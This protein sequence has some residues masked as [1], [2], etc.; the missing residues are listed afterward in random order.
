MADEEQDQKTEYPTQK[1]IQ[2]AM[3][4]GNVP[5][6]REITN[7]LIVIIMAFT[8]GVFAPYMMR[9]TVLL[10]GPFINAPETLAT[11]ATGL[12]HIMEDVLIESM[13]I[14]ALPVIF[15]MA[16]ALISRYAQSGFFISFEV[17]EFKLSKLSP[18]AGIKRIFSARSM[19]EFI[20][21]VFKLLIVGIIGFLAVYPELAHIRQ[22]PDSSIMAI[23][24]FLGK[25][26]LNMLIGVAI[27]MFFIA[28]FDFF[29][30]RYDYHKKLRMTKQEVKDEH[31]QMEGDPKVKSRLRK[32]RMEKA[33]KRMMANVPKADV[34]ITNPTH[35]AVALQYDKGT[36][37]APV[38]TAKG[39]DL[40]A[41]KIREIA[42]ENDVPVVENPPLARAL[43]ES[44]EL[45]R[46]IPV[47]HYEAV[48]KIISYVYKLKGKTF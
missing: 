14:I 33:M 27:A 15:V 39:Q 24:L 30:Q 34:V 21:S 26:S 44:A 10:L 23:M 47:T 28:L 40:I 38:V 37:Q 7:F 3:K 43:Y 32:L 41:L 31:K 8:V 48:A 12:G 35:Y 20:K 16:A 22:L 17:L 4:K 11:D 13:L 29:Y 19:I 5:F 46:E 25:V 42:K 36:M 9:N 2:E 6:S 18:L 45:D 1:R